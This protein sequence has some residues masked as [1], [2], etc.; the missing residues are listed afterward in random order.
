MH[1]GH[2]A[3]FRDAASLGDRLVVAVQSDEGAVACG[4]QKPI[5]RLA[6]RVAA[7]EELGIASE[8][9][10]YDD[11]CDPGL[12]ERVRPDVFTHGDEWVL[13]ADRSRVLAALDSMGAEVVLRPRTAGVSTSSIRQAV[14][15]SG[16]R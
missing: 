16:G 10:V 4:K 14:L 5:Q 2:V 13:D 15:D 9:V 1:R 3:R 8:V 6:D 11:G 12:V 7:V